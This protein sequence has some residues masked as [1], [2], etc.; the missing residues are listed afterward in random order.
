MGVVTTVDT[1]LFT[2]DVE[3]ETVS[4][5]PVSVVTGAP[6]SSVRMRISCSTYTIF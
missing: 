4:N 6:V 5:P 1:T 3:V 2:V